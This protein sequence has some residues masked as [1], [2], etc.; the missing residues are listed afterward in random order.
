METKFNVVGRRLPMHDAAAKVKGSAQFTADLTLPGMLHGK[1][2]RSNIPHGKI[3][4]IDT[5]GAEKLPGVKGV[6]TGKEIPDRLYGIVPK[7]RDEYALAKEKVRYIGDDVAAVCAVDPEIAEEAVQL[8]KVDYEELPAVFDPLEAMKEGAP[9]IHEGVLNNT[10]F[11]I[12]KEFGNAEKGF[13]ESDFVFEDS[14]FSQ[15]VN[16]APLEPHAALAQYDSLRG[17]VTIWSSTQIPFFLRRNLSS[18]LQIPESKVRVIKPK[19]GGGFGQ[20]IDMFAKDFCACWFAIKLGKPVKFVYEREEVFISTRQRH[21]M[22]ITVKTGVKKDGTI[23][24][25]QFKAHADGGAYNSTAPTMI[26]LSC[27]FLMIPYHVPNL[28]YEGHHVYTN[29]PVGGAMR[30]HGIPQ[31]RFAVERQLDMIAERIGVDPAEIRMKNSIHAGEPHPAKFIINSCG[32][33]DSV[34]KAADAIGWKEKRGKL[35]FGR[36]VGLAGASFPSGVSNMSHISSGAVVQL[37][38]DGAVNVLSGAADIGQ[39]AET[40]ISQIVAEELG[41]LMEDVRITAA[42]TGVTP[43]DP[44]TFGSGVTVRAGNAARLAALEAK[45]KLFEFVARKLE[46]NPEDL[47]AANRKIFVKGSPET[48]MTFKDA[49][50]GYQYADLPMPIVGRASWFPPATEP[51][52]LFK[53]DGNFAPS[54]SFMTQSA[55]VEVD[56]DT[57]RV[58]LLKMATAHDCGRA[59]NPM[60]VEGQ[61]EGSVVGGMGQA[62]Y[63]D[64][65]V[66]KG[67]VMNPSFLDYGFPT[68]L[69]MPEIETLEVETDDPIG[70][71]GAKEAGEGTQLSPAP[72]IVNAIYDAIGI[73]FKELPVTPEKILRELEKKRG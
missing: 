73:D 8:I 47:V 32:F 28:V 49:I 58:K 51:T 18:T 9:L 37:G 36:G 7:A 1:I 26:A 60:L 33:F 16:H 11:S 46:A 61:L 56:L 14:F 64:V 53:E 4:H 44:G 22:Y 24:A 41:V 27:F 42:D 30:G 20:K 57:G 54:Y 31:A 2:L 68:F 48:G 72:A 62:L 10:S 52:T 21:P 50:K 63:E 15:A 38:Q 29:K 17:E 67:Q 34:K 25:Q 3:L 65:I 35:P 40:V 43:L 39:G 70:P 66:E 23:L 13:A 45:N 19:V 5:S 12:R 69:E 6:V 59:I 55:E 71:F